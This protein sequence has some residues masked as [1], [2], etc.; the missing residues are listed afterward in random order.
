MVAVD[1]HYSCSLVYFVPV[2]SNAVVAYAISMGMKNKPNI[3]SI[4]R[5][6]KERIVRRERMRSLTYD[7]AVLWI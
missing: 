4:H 1:Y 7:S 2:E 6:G 3:L 5:R